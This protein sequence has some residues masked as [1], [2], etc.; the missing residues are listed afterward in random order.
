VRTHRVATAVALVFGVNRPADDLDPV[1][2]DA[3]SDDS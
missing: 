3:S 1:T 2:Q